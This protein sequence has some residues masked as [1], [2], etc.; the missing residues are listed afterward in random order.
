MLENQIRVKIGVRFSQRL[1]VRRRG[2]EPGVAGSVI[3]LLRT[4]VES[5]PFAGGELAK[6]G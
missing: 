1:V 4:R 3:V 5:P 6:S 2:A